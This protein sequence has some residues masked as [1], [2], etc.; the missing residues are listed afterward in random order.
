VPPAREW[1]WDAVE[2]CGASLSMCFQTYGSE[3][4]LKQLEELREEEEIIYAL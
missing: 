4:V 2:H 3:K 1:V